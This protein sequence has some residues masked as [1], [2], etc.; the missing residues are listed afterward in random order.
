MRVL[1]AGTVA[2]VRI[3]DD[4]LTGPEPVKPR[5]RMILAL[6]LVLGGMAGVAFVLLRQFLNR[7]LQSPEELEDLG[8]N[9]YASIPISQKQ[10]ELDR[11]RE[12]GS[13]EQARILALEHP[14]DL[15]IE[16][17]R[18]LRT[19]L[20]FAMMDA[21]SNVLMLSGPTPG[22]GKS[23]ITSNLGVILAQ[24]GQRVALVDADLRRG[25]M[26]RHFAV[27]NSPGLSDYLAGNANR[28]EVTKKTVHDELHFIPRGHVPP[29]P[30]ELLMH[31]RMR[32]LV[33][34]LANKYDIVII[35]TPPILA[36]TDPAIVGQ[37]A[38]AC[39]TIVRH[40][41]NHL[42]EVEIAHKRFEQNGLKVRGTIL[43]GM[44]YSRANVYG[45][46]P[47]RYGN[48]DGK[49]KG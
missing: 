11:E 41:V 1:E 16:A 7:S 14:S 28:A 13:G 36:V 30:A 46:Y 48:D 38:G 17:L 12:Q 25:H 45:Y 49:A 32:Q 37:Y 22:V 29:N 9:V 5:K 23:F 34:E 15:T 35:D 18:A 21:Y 42:K 31:Q 40:G 6:S 24:A 44:R 47:Y 26:H 39:M 19:S 4:A 27:R 33:D 2:N 3:I 8:L 20:H 43:N 10:L